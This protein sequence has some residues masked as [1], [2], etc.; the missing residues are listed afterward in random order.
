MWLLS[1]SL[2]MIIV[3]VTGTVYEWTPN[4]VA[5]GIVMV[6]SAWVFTKLVNL[7]IWIIKPKHTAR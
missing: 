5:L 7:L 3:G 2:I 6:F 1:Q 4:K